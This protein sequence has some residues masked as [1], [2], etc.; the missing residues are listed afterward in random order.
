MSAGLSSLSEYDYKCLA[1]R[2]EVVRLQAKSNS[3][4][5]WGFLLPSWKMNSLVRRRSRKSASNDL[6]CILCVRE[7]GDT[8]FIGS[9]RNQPKSLERETDSRTRSEIA[10]I[11]SKTENTMNYQLSLKW[12]VQLTGRMS[13]MVHIEITEIDTIAGNSTRFPMIKT[14]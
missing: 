2:M 4:L 1:S 8:R 11:E 10:S 3:I 14:R 13:I 7:D 5:L 12:T 9:A 6:G